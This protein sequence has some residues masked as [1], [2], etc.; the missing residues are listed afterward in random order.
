MKYLNWLIYFICSNAAITSYV[1]KIYLRDGFRKLDLLWLQ[2]ALPGDDA[3]KIHKN[4]HTLFV[5]IC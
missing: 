3:F 2:Y 4:Y 5:C 1:L